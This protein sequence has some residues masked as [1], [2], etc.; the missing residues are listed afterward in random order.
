[1]EVASA[2]T[3][4]AAH[5][6]FQKTED[7]ALDPGRQG[8]A[9]DATT[10]GVIAVE[11]AAI[12][13]SPDLEAEEGVIAETVVVSEVVTTRAMKRKMVSLRTEKLSLTMLMVPMMETITVTETVADRMMSWT[14]L[15]APIKQ[16]TTTMTI[17]DLLSR[18]RMTP[19]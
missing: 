5:A 8:T 12:M 15:T 4:G 14:A 3:I 16:Q 2:E 17:T 19:M 9:V 13:T 7:H 1:M 6:L 10:I 11:T 18:I